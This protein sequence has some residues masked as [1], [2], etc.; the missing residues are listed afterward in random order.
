MDLP[1]RCD[2]DE[3]ATLMRSGDLTG[4]DRL[5]RCQ[6]ERLLAV[7]RRYCRDEQD[8]RDAVQDA[9][10]TAGTHLE[11]F[12]GDGSAEG[13]V[14]R[15]VARACGRMRRGRRNDPALHVHDVEVV[16]PELD[17]ESLAGRARIAEALGTALLEL[18]PKDRAVLLLAE[19]EG[20]TGP[21]IAAEL[22]VTPNAVRT[23]LSRARRTVRER[24][25]GLRSPS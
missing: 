4:L 14:V 23:R 13:W 6:G 7:G 16:A 20:W 10:L 11:D 1:T 17:P 2:P 12:R 24:L 15:M 3:I 22:G 25:D 9:L 5:T 8:A 18:P 19:A 21:E